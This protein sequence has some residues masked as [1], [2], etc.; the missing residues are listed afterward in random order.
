MRLVALSFAS[1]V[2]APLAACGSDDDGYDDV[3]LC[4]QETSKDEFV[5]GLQK[6]GEAGTFDFS[7]TSF[8]PAPPAQ[9]NN[10]WS[11]MVMS[12]G[13]AAA[14]VTGAELLVTPFMPKHQHGPGIDPEVTPTATDGEYDV[15]PI[16]LWMPG[17]WEVTIEVEAGGQTDQ[18]VF[19]ACIPS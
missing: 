7:L 10:A 17:I 14:P 1:L 2:L 3:V 4:D 11:V 19:R 12:T 18:A 6:A 5:I 15:T 8:S 16:N 13:A 9:G